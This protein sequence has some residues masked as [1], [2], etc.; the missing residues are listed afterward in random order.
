LLVAP[1]FNKEIPTNGHNKQ[2]YRSQDQGHKRLWQSGK[3]RWWGGLYLHVSPTG[4]KLWWMAYRLDKKQQTASLGP[5]PLV[6]LA[7]ARVKL[8]NLKRSLLNGAIRQTSHCI[9]LDRLTRSMRGQMSS[10]ADRAWTVNYCHC[11]YS[12]EF[13]RATVQSHVVIKVF[14]SVTLCRA[15]PEA[16]SRRPC[17]KTV[18]W[19]R[20]S[21][22]TFKLMGFFELLI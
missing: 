22:V 13:W 6:T 14:Q 17:M 7:E 18:G 3:T 4:G 2:T 5:C 10:G 15:L 12:S 19:A 20:W 11:V 21:A 9:S 1:Y 16:S 8:D